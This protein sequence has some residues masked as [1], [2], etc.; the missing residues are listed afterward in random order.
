[1]WRH[2]SIL[3]GGRPSAGTRVVFAGVGFTADLDRDEVLTDALGVATTRV[4]VGADLTPLSFTAT[5]EAPARGTCPPSKATSDEVNLVVAPETADVAPDGD[6]GAGSH[7]R[8]LSL[9]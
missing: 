2:R 4:R 8:P 9:L 1:M 5:A 3:A 6:T 7:R